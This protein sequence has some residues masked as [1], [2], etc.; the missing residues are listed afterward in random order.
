MA[1]NLQERGLVVTVTA[2]TGGVVSG[3]AFLLQSTLCVALSDAV[4]TADVEV[5]IEGVYKNI[6]AAD[7][8]AFAELAPL[9]WDTDEDELVNDPDDGDDGLY[10]FVGL[11]IGGKA[12]ADDSC[13]IKLIPTGPVPLAEIIAAAT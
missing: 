12:T 9:Y 10:P 8:A 7:D 13:S 1:R 6:P 2:P 3:Q 5:A 11:C 4:A